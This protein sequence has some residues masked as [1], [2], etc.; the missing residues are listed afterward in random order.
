MF[1]RLSLIL[2]VF[3]A[4]AFQSPERAWGRVQRMAIAPGHYKIAPSGSRGVSAF[5]LDPDLPSP[6][7]T[8][9]F[10]MVFS[11]PSSVRVQV[12]AREMSLQ[13]ALLEKLI[14]IKGEDSYDFSQLQILNHTTQEVSLQFKESA[15]VAEQGERAPLVTPNDLRELGLG[16]SAGIDNVNQIEIQ[17]KIWSTSELRSIGYKTTSTT[18]SSSLETAIRQF[19]KDNKLPETGKLNWQSSGILEGMVER[20]Q[21]IEET[22]RGSDKQFAIFFI[23]LQEEPTKTGF[24]KIISEEQKPAFVNT[25]E[26]IIAHANG[27]AQKHST[28]NIYVALEGIRSQEDVDAFGLSL[29]AKQKELASNLTIKPMETGPHDDLSS[30]FFMVG[31]KVERIPGMTIKK[32]TEGPYKDFF[33]ASINVTK[34]GFKQKVL[35]IYAKTKEILEHFLL[36]LFRQDTRELSVAALVNKA[37]TEVKRT[38]KLTEAELVVEFEDEF[39]NV[40]VVK[41]KTLFEVS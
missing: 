38:F 29:R 10:Q 12:G 32:V 7:S 36:L 22:K 26:E 3:F 24:Y 40:Q 11:D 19:Q 34:D 5:C 23:Q 39:G 4:V 35:Y 30:H 37:R 27:I 14:S 16:P 6:S 8:S 18:G 21:F 31:G 17:K 1:A 28:Q 13:Q 25:P 9:S 41:L 2:F 15:I 20:K 33:E